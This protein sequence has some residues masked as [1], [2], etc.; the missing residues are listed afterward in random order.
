MQVIMQRQLSTEIIAEL[1][2]R[3]ASAWDVLLEEAAARHVLSETEF[4][5]EMTDVRLEKYLVVDEDDHIVGMTTVTTDLNAIPW[6]N[7]TYY[8]H[9]YPQ[10]ADSGTL[11]YLGY[12]FVDTGHRRSAALALMSEAVNQRLVET[13]GVIC[14]DICGYNTARAIGRHLER[15]FSSGT[16]I[17]TLDT[18]TYFAADYR[19]PRK[20]RDLRTAATSYRCET[21]ADRLDLTDDVRAL[22]VEQWPP[23]MLGGHQAHGVEL[24]PMLLEL[25]DQ[26]VLLLD[27]QDVVCGAGFVVPL[28]WDGRPETVPSG[29]DDSIVQGADLVS[30]GGVGDTLCALS[31]TV[32]R[33]RT[34]HGLAGRIVAGLK[35]VAVR[36]G[37]HS[38]ISPIRPTDKASYPLISLDSYLTWTRGTGEPFDPWVR[39]HTKLG[40]TIVGT[41][42][43]S[44]VI[45]G[46]VKEWEAWTGEQFPGSGSYVIGGGLVPLEIDHESDQGRY[47]EPNLWVQHPVP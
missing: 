33:D 6:I 14:F 39:L 16:E 28:R 35:E 43:E 29:W 20:L 26:Q 23:Y 38:V 37:A 30:R 7:P 46:S 34:G 22:L 45:T 10:Q 4:H 44:M 36:V 24:E 17:H 15:L 42:P 12:A 27:G 31:I 47:V 21:L 18:Q 19:T 32:R 9:R 1:Y 41:A 2:P 11:F 5:Q 8:L 40:A 13:R 3:Y 25:A